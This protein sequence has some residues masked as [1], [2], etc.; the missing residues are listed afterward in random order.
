MGEVIRLPVREKGWIEALSVDSH[1]STM[2][3]YVRKETGEAEIVQ[4]N[5]EG[6]AI[7]TTLSQ[8]DVDDMLVALTALKTVCKSR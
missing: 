6:E 1:V 5:D 7:R 3:L 8:Q 4:H 2:Q